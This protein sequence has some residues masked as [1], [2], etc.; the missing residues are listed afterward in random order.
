MNG[1]TTEVRV[2]IPGSGVVITYTSRCERDRSL[3]LAEARQ[4][5]AHESGMCPPWADLTEADRERSAMDARY[6]LTAAIRAGIAAP[7][8]VHADVTCTAPGEW[9]GETAAA[10]RH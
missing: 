9:A 2:Q 7:C 3:R 4:D 10:L 1:N 8:P 5:L 6:W